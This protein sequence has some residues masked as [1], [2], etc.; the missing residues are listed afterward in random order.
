MFRTPDQYGY[1]LASVTPLHDFT[2]AVNGKITGS[3]LLQHYAGYVP[4]DEETLSDTF[5]E[6]GI[7][8]SKSFHLYKHYTL[9][10][11][12]GVKNLLNQF[13][14][15]LDKGSSRDASYIYGPAVPRTWF[16]GFNIKL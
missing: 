15:D 12:A 9:E 13:Q 4:E 14:P 7:K 2:I 3:M 11:N 8:I 1:F 6:L 10:L 16:A 5:F